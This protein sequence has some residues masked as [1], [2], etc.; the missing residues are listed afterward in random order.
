MVIPETDQAHQFDNLSFFY[1]K[2]CTFFFIIINFL[3]QIYW[4]NETRDEEI[5]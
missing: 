2:K 1:Y 3:T 5:C 4:T